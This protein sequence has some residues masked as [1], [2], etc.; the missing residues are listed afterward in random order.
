MS[1]QPIGWPQAAS[2][3]GGSIGGGPGEAGGNGFQVFPNIMLFI[4]GSGGAGAG[5]GATGTTAD[6]GSK[7]GKGAYG[8]GGGGGGGGFTGTTGG[9]GGDGGDG[10]VIITSW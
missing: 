4:G 8:C 2:V 1:N 7:G 10:L 6:T 9:R 5:A 3:F